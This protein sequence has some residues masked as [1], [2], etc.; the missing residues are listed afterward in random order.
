MTPRVQAA[1][2]GAGDGEG[3]AV[4]QFHHQRVR[5]EHFEDR[6]KNPPSHPPPPKKTTS[7]TT[8]TLSPSEDTATID[9]STPTLEELREV[10]MNLKNNRFMGMQ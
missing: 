1:F 3:G 6:Q 9:T 8:R 5:H 7:K 4:E 10:C 2:G